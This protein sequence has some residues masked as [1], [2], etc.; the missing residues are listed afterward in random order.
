MKEEIKAPVPPFSYEEAVLKVR[1][2]ENAWNSKD[3]NKISFAYTKDSKWRNRDLFINGRDEIVGFLENKFTKEKEYRLCK[4]LWAYT[5][6]KI[7]VRFAYEWKD[8]NNQW[9]RSYGNENWEFD[10]N[11]L[12][13][14]RFACINDLKIDTKDRKLNWEGSTRPEDFPSLSDL[15]L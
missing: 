7:A 10:K 4:E 11:G 8:E 1:M 6:N 13:Q 2:A 12:M 9:Y 3:A 14:K 5:D 15:N